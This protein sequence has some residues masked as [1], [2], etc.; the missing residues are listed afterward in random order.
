MAT[1]KQTIID[2]VPVEEIFYRHGVHV[3]AGK[4]C[5][6]FHADDTPSLSVYDNGRKWHCFGCGQGGNVIDAEMLFEQLSFIEAICQLDSDYKLGLIAD[7]D[8]PVPHRPKISVH[9]I[10]AKEQE[11]YR[12]IRQD[13][14]EGYYYYSSVLRR[15]KSPSFL[16]KAEERE[17]WE[18]VRLREACERVYEELGSVKL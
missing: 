1:A 18:A 14:L 11:R 5:C 10:A 15:F 12:Q 4:C 7:A 6:P 9:T 16:S 17:F 3:K 13:A 2:T 8:D